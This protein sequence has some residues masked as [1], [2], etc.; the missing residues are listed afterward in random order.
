MT[1]VRRP[2]PRGEFM[3]LRQAMDRLFDDDVFRPFRWT[4]GA[5]DGPGLPLDVTTTPTS[6]WS[7]PRSRA[8]SPRTSRSPWRTAP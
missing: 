3:T 4:A 5:F 8:S 6:S 1:I 7:R 2:S